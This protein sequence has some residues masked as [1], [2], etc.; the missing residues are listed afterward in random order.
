[1]LLRNL[2]T[3]LRWIAPALG[4]A[5]L[6]AALRSGSGWACAV[7]LPPASLLLAGGLLLAGWHLRPNRARVDRTLVVEDWDIVSD[8]MHNS[9]TDLI[10]LEPSFFLV[11]AVSP[12]HFAS[13]GCVLALSTS[14]DGRHWQRLATF[15]SPQEDIRDPKLAVIGNRLFLYALVNRSFDPEPY[16]TVFAVSEDGGRTWTALQRLANEGWLFW[17]PR[18]RDGLTWY[19]AAYW[20]EHGRSALFSSTD[21]IEWSKVATIF[22]GGRRNDETDLAFLPDGRMLATSRLE[23]DFREWGYGMFF[24]DPTGATLISAADPPYTGFRIT[25]E[26]RLTRLDGPALFSHAGRTFAVGRFQPE[27]RQPFLRQG[28]L[29]ARKRTAL[30][31]VTSEGLVWL[32]DLPSAGDTS[33]AGVV[34]HAGSA[35]ISYYTSPIDHDVPWIIGMANPTPIR[36]ARVDLHRLA[37]LAAPGRP[38]GAGVPA[39]ASAVGPRRSN[40]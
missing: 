4:A 7:L 38:P 28:S 19:A 13:T 16:T 15:S 12:H 6:A 3:L 35:Y 8:D 39:D 29:F 22:D 9:N 26:S 30:F 31:E 37:A 10:R 1:M 14:G 2:V 5:L 11:H 17:K 18:T 25:G 32:S 20:H 23:G 36:M 33:Y 27:R 21:G 34:L 40:A 24:G